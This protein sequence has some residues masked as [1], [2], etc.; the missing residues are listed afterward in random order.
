MGPIFT[1][2]L[3]I[4]CLQFFH[5]MT[6]PDPMWPPVATP[7]PFILC[8]TSERTLA[9]TSHEVSTPRKGLP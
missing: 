3:F 2:K 4:V 9:V 5:L 7:S 6:R 8:V 1:E